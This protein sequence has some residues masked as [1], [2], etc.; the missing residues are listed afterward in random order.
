[1]VPVK[2]IFSEMF[3]RKIDAAS[4]GSIIVDENCNIIYL[5]KWMRQVSGKTN[6]FSFGK[7]LFEVFNLKE[8]SRVSRSILI[9]CKEGKSALLSP[10]F[11]PHPLPLQRIN[12]KEK[13]MVQKIAIYSLRNENGTRFIFIDI[14]DLSD[15]AERELYLRNTKKNLNKIIESI[16]ELLFVVNNDFSI[17]QIN[18]KALDVLKYEK[19][20]L[21]SQQFS[22]VIENK[23]VSKSLQV[24]FKNLDNF[25]PLKDNEIEILTKDG[26]SIPVLFSASII[27]LENDTPCLVVTMKDISEKKKQDLEIKKKEANLLA[28]SKLTALGE[29]AGQMA[30][31]IN[32]PLQVVS[33]HAGNIEKLLDS[34]EPSEDVEKMKTSSETIGK[35]VTRITKI[36]KGLSSLSRMS[37]N[38]TLIPQKVSELID[39]TAILCKDRFKSA[40]IDFEVNNYAPNIIIQ[41]Q[42]VQISQTLINILNNAHDAIVGLAAK[43]IK[44]KIE[45]D[46]N[47][48]FIRIIDSGT[49]FPIDLKDKIFDPFFTTKELGKGTGIGLGISKNIINSHKG[50]IWVDTDSPNTCFV[51]KLPIFKDKV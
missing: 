51:I 14:F 43:W 2:K 31:E 34:I 40:G 9:A 25:T 7:K 48:V 37:E 24:I 4:Y 47:Y 32:N 15:S 11:N 17:I 22:K 16:Q 30:H 12:S 49:D 6:E 3:Y 8:T 28:V 1:M 45:T 29:M 27:D 10:T 5:N 50:D 36:I 38:D 39:E 18:D 26:H 33:Y 42:P 35:M 13:L 41:C 44:I 20:E 46:E 23:F 21:L 19:K